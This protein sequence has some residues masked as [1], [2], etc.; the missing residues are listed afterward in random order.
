M[1]DLRKEF[2]RSQP[3]HKDMFGRVLEKAPEKEPGRMARKTPGIYEKLF[4]RKPGEVLQKSKERKKDGP[5][6]CST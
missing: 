2:R 6:A 4:H 5:R 3:Q 1:S